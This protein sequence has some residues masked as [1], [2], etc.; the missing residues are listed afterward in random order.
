MSHLPTLEIAIKGFS[1]PASA[2]FGIIFARFKAE[3]LKGGDVE[4]AS[5]C[6]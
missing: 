1:I 6:P 4:G 3:R 5:R 2:P